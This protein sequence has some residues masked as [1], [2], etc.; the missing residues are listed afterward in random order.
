MKNLKTNERFMIAALTLSF[1][2]LVATLIL[3][4]DY[5]ARTVDLPRVLSLSTSENTTLVSMSAPMLSESAVVS[6]S[7]T[8][9]DLDVPNTDMHSEQTKKPTQTARS[10]ETPVTKP[11]GEQH[12][13]QN[14]ILNTN[15][16]KVHSSWCSYAQNI[17][18]ENR[19]DISSAEVNSYLGNGYTVCSRCKALERA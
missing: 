13:D 6:L 9:A 14:L 1:L 7:E 17:K 11:A 18:A 12:Y 4:I 15:S 8:N 2:F 3:Q 5:S 10:T 19:K 16:K